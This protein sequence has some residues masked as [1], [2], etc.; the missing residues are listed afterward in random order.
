VL[1]H[2]IELH[3]SQG[4]HRIG[5]TRGIVVFEAPSSGGS[6]FLELAE[7]EEK[8]VGAYLYPPENPDPEFD[9]LLSDL[10]SNFQLA[11]TD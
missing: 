5:L 4:W 3:L 11:V 9:R 7:V 2:L 1:D 10:V 6:L 8:I